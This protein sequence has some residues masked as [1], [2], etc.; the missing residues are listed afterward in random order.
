MAWTMTTTTEGETA[1][2]IFLF[3]LLLIT[4]GLLFL[5]VRH[6]VELLHLLSDLFEGDVEASGVG[7]LVE[8]FSCNVLL[9][10]ELT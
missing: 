5:V 1:A 6:K 8:L 3:F 4:L 7:H 10:H 2:W 9:L